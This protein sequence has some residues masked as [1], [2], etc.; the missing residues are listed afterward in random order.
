MEGLSHATNQQD[1]RDIYR[2][3][4]PT[5]TECTF[6]SSAHGTP[7]GPQSKSQQIKRSETIQSIFSGY[8]RFTVEIIN[9]R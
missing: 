5:T 7:P 6:F 9:K 3:F 4:P 8:K 1:L 2:T